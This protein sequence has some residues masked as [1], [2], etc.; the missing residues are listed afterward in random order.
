MIA[1]H[2]HFI[3]AVKAFAIAFIV[4]TPIVWLSLT[5]I[6]FQ[7]D[8]TRIG[9]ISDSLFAPQKY[10]LDLFPQVSGGF[11][12]AEILVIG[13]SFS[14]N[15]QWQKELRKH[16]SNSIATITWE[17]A[18]NGCVTDKESPFFFKGSTIIFQS[19]ERNFKRNL[20][21]QLPCITPN[22]AIQPKNLA[23][24]PNPKTKKFFDLNGQFLVGISTFFNTNLIKNID[25]YYKVYNKYSS[26]KI[27]PIEDGCNYFSNVLCK[28]ALIYKP[29][30]S[31]ENFSLNLIEKMKNVNESLEK[32]RLIW[33]V[34]PN[35]YSVYVDP[36]NQE[37][38]K[39]IYK[40]KLGPDLFSDFIN[41]KKV[42]I[43]LYQPND[44]HLSGDGFTL[45]GKRVNSF[46]S[47]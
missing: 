32:K 37:F 35:K 3:N 39:L 26:A 40:N 28:Y 20:L 44:T 36:K 10:T 30:L 1:D 16:T 2:K 9:K 27:I 42:V 4:I 14:I 5:Q 47:N 25:S 38:G 17:D 19:V 15:L 33:V 13:D 29:D 43:D 41:N 8:L 6:N 22:L 24:A 31:T 7:G 34:V 12:E 23:Y 18:R 45:L 46:I 21:S 11:N